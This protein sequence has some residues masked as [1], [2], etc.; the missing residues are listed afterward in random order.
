VKKNIAIVV[1][2]VVAALGLT[3]TGAVAG[4]GIGKGNIGSW[5]I[6]D[7]TIKGKDLRPGIKEKVKN[8]NKALRKIENNQDQWSEDTKVVPFYSES[9]KDQEIVNTGGSWGTL[10]DPRATQLDSVML[11][12]GKYVITTE[13]FFTEIDGG[14]PDAAQ[15]QIAVRMADGSN[16]GVDLGTCFTTTGTAPG[17]DYTCSTT[18][19]VTLT[20]ETEVLVFGFGYN[21]NDQSGSNSGEFEAE[22]YLTALSVS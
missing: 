16:W 12:A 1:L 10:A 14:N 18:R 11:P 4:I 8:G 5:H 22:S 20:E 7:G 9:D 13:G 6:A 3:T 15:L 21:V 19:T 17:R 2:A